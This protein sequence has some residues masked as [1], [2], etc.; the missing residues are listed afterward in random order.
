M[1]SAA[2]LALALTVNGRVVQL[3]SRGFDE[4][5]AR[6]LMQ[7]VGNAAVPLAGKDREGTHWSCA[8]QRLPGAP[9]AA[10]LRCHEWLLRLVRPCS[11]DACQWLLIER[12]VDDHIGR[13]TAPPRAV[14]SPAP[15]PDR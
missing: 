15:R 5:A 12:R 11:T 10:E 1:S 2:A 3:Q 6:R 7:D 14:S 4:P 8:L 13:R 9:E